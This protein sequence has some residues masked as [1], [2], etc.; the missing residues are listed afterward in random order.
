MEEDEDRIL[1]NSLGIATANPEDIERDVLAEATRNN[2]NNGEGGG[3]PEEETLEKPEG[4]D[5]SS[6]SKAKLYHKLRAVEFEIDAVASTVEQARNV[7]SDEDRA[8]DG[9][10]SGGLGNKE[11][12]GQVSPNGLDLQHALAADRLRSLEK[13]RAQL[14]ILYYFNE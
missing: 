4:I 11:D 9:N 13:T 10:D 12:S 7:A 14:N 8:G 6:T 2:E 1:L 5:P 3:G